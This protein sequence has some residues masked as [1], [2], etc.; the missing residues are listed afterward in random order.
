M[1]I[2]VISAREAALQKEVAELREERADL[3]HKLHLL[4]LDSDLIRT[5]AGLVN[6]KL[7]REINKLEKKNA[8]LNEERKTLLGN[9]EFLDA[10][11]AGDSVLINTM[12]SHL[13]ECHAAL[14][15]LLEKKPMFAAFDY[16]F[17]SASLG[18]L[19]AELGVYKEKT[20]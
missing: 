2:T 12:Q 15:M 9:I 4:Q 13:R 8:A 1:T 18:N 11:L 20:E 19:L 10:L 14:S 3:E 16:G 6:Q 5:G 7:C 17:G